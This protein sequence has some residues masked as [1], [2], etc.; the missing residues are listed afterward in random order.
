M[1][2]VETIATTAYHRRGRSDHLPLPLILAL[3][4][5]LIPVTAACSSSG[6]EPDAGAAPG[7]DASARGGAGGSAR[8]GAGGSAR[9]GAGGRA[10]AAAGVG[11][12]RRGWFGARRCGW[13]DRRVRCGRLRGGGAGGSLGHMSAG[14][15]MAASGT[16]SYVRQTITV[17]G[18]QREYFLY[19]PSTYDPGHPYPIVFRWHGSGGN[20]TSGGLEIEAASK[21][22]AIIASPSGLNGDW[23]FSPTGVDVQLFD[24]LLAALESRYCIDT[25]RV[26]SY[27]FSD[28]AGFT[29]LLG[30]VRS[31]TVRAVAPVEGW[32]P[33]T[34]CNG[35]V[36]AW[37]T[38]S[39]DDTVITIDRGMAALDLFTMLDGCG[40][41][42]HGHHA[43]ALHR[44]PGLS[45]ELSR[46][47]V[48][49]HRTTQSPERL[50][51][52]GRVGV[53]QLAPLI[54]GLRSGVGTDE[55]LSRSRRR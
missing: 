23:D 30:C 17:Q 6:S 8:G 45:V 43:L 46:R 36:A 33:Q 10:R 14:C 18:T 15:G 40:S 32:A 20:G 47:L 44:L 48:P 53:L 22:K 9:G 49:D 1:P 41:T 29:N 21:E 38:H 35:P 52:S 26:F 39:I 25:N 7:A 55:A 51:G 34:K 13:F 16:S 19:I 11:A 24:A 42:S 54:T 28:G 3:C 27:G 5:A 31:P 50:R 2:R 37:I 12:R 4:L